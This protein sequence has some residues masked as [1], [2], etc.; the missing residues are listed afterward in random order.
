MFRKFLLPALAVFGVMFAIYSVVTG[1]RQIPPAQPVAEPAQPQFSS[2]V[3]GA[4]LVEASTENIAVGTLVPGVVTEIY[5]KRGD[6]VLAGAPLFKIDDRDLQAELTVR[7]AALASAEAMVKTQQ[8]SLADVKDQFQR[9]QAVADTRA[10]SQ[11]ELE[12]RRYAA[13]I[14]EAKLN[15]AQADLTSAQAQ[16][17]ANTTGTYIQA[18][19]LQISELKEERHTRTRSWTAAWSRPRSTASCSR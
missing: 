4:G 18:A 16:V 10:V 15:Q 19:G 13:V 17:K 6:Q 8:A 11:D 1:Q 2:Y 5:V 7:K 14:Q 3:A 9:M 12:R